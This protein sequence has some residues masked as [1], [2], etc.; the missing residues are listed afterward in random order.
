M[1]QLLKFWLG[2][3]WYGVLHLCSLGRQLSRVMEFTFFLI[4]A[5]GAG[6]KFCNLS[7]VGNTESTTRAATQLLFCN[8]KKKLEKYNGMFSLR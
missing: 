2:E 7:L 3:I 6:V 5:D 1:G 4:P 8:H